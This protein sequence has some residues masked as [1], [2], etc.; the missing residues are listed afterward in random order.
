LGIQS[1]RSQLN[2]RTLGRQTSIYI[3]RN[4]GLSISRSCGQGARIA[5]ARSGPHGCIAFEI[6][7][8]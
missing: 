8:S 1:A 5:A 2:A 4:S 7:V 3:G 6:A